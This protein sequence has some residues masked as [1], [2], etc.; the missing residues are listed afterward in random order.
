MGCPL[1]FQKLKVKMLLD[2]L[3]EIFRNLAM[4]DLLRCRQVCWAWR[5]VINRD[6]PKE[7]C[8][9][10]KGTYAPDVWV[11]DC[12]LIDPRSALTVDRK[13]AHSFR[14]TILLCVLCGQYTVLRY[15]ISLF[16]RNHSAVWQRA[17]PGNYRQQHWRTVNKMFSPNGSLIS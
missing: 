7:L 10:V 9:Y 3:P 1:K 16:S 4:K 13:E 11:I 15:L 5:H 2:I 12:E 6:F 8:L 17:L 14:S